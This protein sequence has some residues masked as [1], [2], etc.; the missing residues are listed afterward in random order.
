[1]ILLDV[2]MAVVFDYLDSNDLIQCNETNVFTENEWFS[3][4]SQ[5]KTMIQITKREHLKYFRSARFVDLWGMGSFLQDKDLKELTRLHTLNLLDCK[6]YY[7]R[8]L[9]ISQKTAYVASFWLLQNYGFWNEIS[10]IIAYVECIL[11]YAA[12]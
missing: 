11:V 3:V 2:L 6:K 10:F 8:G 4:I 7:G 9:K 12:Y 1:M 5:T